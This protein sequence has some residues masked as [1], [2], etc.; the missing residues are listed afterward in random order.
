MDTLI[1]N[2]AATEKRYAFLR[3]GKVE[4]IY[5]EQPK[6]QSLVGNIYYGTVTKVL[7]GMNAVFVDI[8]EEKQA[9]LHRDK[10]VS[11]AVASNEKGT[12]EN[13][14]VSSFVHQGERLLVQVEKDEAGTKGARLTGII[15]LSGSHIVYMPNGRYV[16]VS[17]KIQP[18][19]KNVGW[20]NFGAS[21]KEENEGIL[22]RTSCENQ[23]HETIQSELE[24]LRQQYAEIMRK[25]QGMKKTGVLLRTDNFQ[26]ELIDVMTKM[27]Q[28]EVIVDDPE[29]KKKLQKI[30]ELQDSNLT[31]TYYRGKESI[32]HAFQLEN[33]IDK[34]LKRM[35]W[36]DSGA[37]LVIDETEALTI[38]DVNTGKFS[39]KTDLRDTVKKTNLLAAA[40]A[41]RQLRLRDIGGIVLIDFIDMKYDKDREE[42]AQKVL[43]EL[44]K[45][46]K[47]TKVLG[48]TSLGIL[49]I[50]RKKTKPSLLESM[51]E[52]CHVC[53]GTGR[54]QSSESIAFQ[55][56]RELWENKHSD[57]SSLWIETT[58]E[59]KKLLEGEGGVH[60]KRLEDA[61]GL[62]I[63]L[64][65]V[66]SIKP[67]YHIKKFS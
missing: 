56:E 58:A 32:F 14:T 28:G 57:Y 66:S 6:Q 17:K 39:G 13:K 49:Q 21:V 26:E 35:V 31:F 2:Y 7:P 53:D 9:Y 29:L 42:V 48:F 59:V 52:R 15:E 36:L 10:L 46:E 67:F 23:T 50:T 38:I 45:D 40:E 19:D 65:V 63:H 4:K 41:V 44:K 33:E 34:A 11:Y 27:G 55:L 54:V 43:M 18:E 60:L 47:Q 51:T 62:T 5:I 8:G 25:T 20:R 64:E 30:M 22:F 37:Y 3:N 1:I 24:E 61:I 12:K 16:A